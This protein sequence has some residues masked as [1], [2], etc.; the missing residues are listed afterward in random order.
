M[1]L[2]LQQSKEV[3][4]IITT[5]LIRRFNPRTLSVCWKSGKLM[6]S[7]QA[8]AQVDPERACRSYAP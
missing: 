3:D 1:A 7:W 5:A 8:G 6:C 2:F 4:I